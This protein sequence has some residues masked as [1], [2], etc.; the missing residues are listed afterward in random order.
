MNEQKP[1]SMPAWVSGTD[2]P[3]TIHGRPKGDKSFTLARDKMSIKE[4]LA[5]PS[6]QLIKM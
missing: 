5:N 3:E 2:E 1:R 6:S 4:A